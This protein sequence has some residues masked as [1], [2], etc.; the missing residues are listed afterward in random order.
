MAGKYQR[1]LGYEFLSL[2]LRK[3]QDRLKVIEVF[4]LED[5]R[6][7]YLGFI[8]IQFAIVGIIVNRIY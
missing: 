1:I 3:L 4:Q 2:L 5:I 7:V 6:Y 8:L